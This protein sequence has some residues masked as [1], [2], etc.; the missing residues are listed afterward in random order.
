MKYV[1]TVVLIVLVFG[2]LVYSEAEA[3]VMFTHLGWE[4][5]NVGIDENGETIW[6]EHYFVTIV[7]ESG[8]EATIEISEEE[9]MALLTE[10]FERMRGAKKYNQKWYEKVGSWLTFWDPND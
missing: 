3:E 10:H 4:S 9:N 2:F 7:S 1:A 5:R 8:D 6:E